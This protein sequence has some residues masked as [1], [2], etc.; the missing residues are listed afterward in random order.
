MIKRKTS[1]TPIK[2]RSENLSYA[3]DHIIAS[4]Q[5]GLLTAH[6]NYIT[7]RSPFYRS[8]FA[9]IK[10]D[11]NDVTGLDGLALLPFTSKSDLEDNHNDFIAAPKNKLVDLCLTSGTT[12]KPVAMLQT[13]SDLKRLTYNEE[14][15]FRA[16]GITNSDKVLIA[17]ASDRCFMAGLAYFLGLTKIN[18]L[19]LRGGS[20]SPAFTMELIK[21]AG[22]TAIVGIPSLLLQFGEKLQQ[23]GIEPGDLGIKRIV[24]I[25]EPVR[26]SDLALSPLGERLSTLWHTRIF[27]TYAS[28]EMATSFTDCEE[29]VGGHLIPELMIVEV[30]DESG[31]R[32]PHGT[33]GEVVATPLGVTGM[34]ILRFKTGDIATIHAD[35]CRCGRNSLRLG[36]VVC[37]KSQMLKCRG[38]TVYPPA[39]FSVLQGIPGIQGFYVEVEHEFDLSDRIRVFVGVSDGSLPA[40][41]IAEKIAGTIRVKPEVIVI[42]PEDIF[43]KTLFDDKRKPITFFD[44]RKTL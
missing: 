15:S 19:V 12:G 14:Q 44:R 23:E 1:I 33:A 37:R 9:D 29:G 6:I 22:P 25:G 31:V 8:M 30:V 10:C 13:S 34:P 40:A 42:K 20:S 41:F 32:V 36:P 2:C 11:P 5:A 17:V 43:K 4:R 21:N 38:T 35:P 3:P 7:A 28:T 24:C 18:A 39:I 27:G 26:G 16:A